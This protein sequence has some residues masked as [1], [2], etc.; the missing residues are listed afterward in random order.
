LAL[1]LF[2]K[3]ILAQKSHVKYWWNW[4]QVSISSTFWR[5]NFV[6]KT[7]EYNVDEIDYRCHIMAL[8]FKKFQSHFC[9]CSCCISWVI[10]FYKTLFKPMKLQ[11]YSPISRY[12]T[13]LLCSA[14]RTPVIIDVEELPQGHFR[15]LSFPWKCLIHS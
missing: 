13:L 5:Q 3:R 6:Q 4:L 15:A 2:G 7:R 11:V 1:W 10:V 14:L 12:E 8:S 9:N